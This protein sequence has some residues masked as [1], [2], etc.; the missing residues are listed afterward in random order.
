MVDRKAIHRHG[1]AMASCWMVIL[2]I[3]PESA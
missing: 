2:P 1:V 3:N